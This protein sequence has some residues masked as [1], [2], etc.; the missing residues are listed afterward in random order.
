V[1]TA[2]LEMQSRGFWLTSADRFPFEIANVDDKMSVR[3][4][5]IRRRIAIDRLAWENRLFAQ[6]AR[7]HELANQAK[8]WWAIRAETL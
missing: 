4:N 5:Q 2:W 6:R 3:R 8:N 7:E 1:K